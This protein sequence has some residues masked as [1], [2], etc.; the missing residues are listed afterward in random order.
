M[1]TRPRNSQKQELGVIGLGFDN[2]DGH[3]RVTEGKD[4][5]LVGGSAETHARMTD[6]VIR[7]RERAERRGKKLRDLSKDEFEDI[8]HESFE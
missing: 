1:T 2:D 7:M 8:A 5:A 4:F 6:L 3:K